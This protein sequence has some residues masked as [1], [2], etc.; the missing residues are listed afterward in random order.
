MV[1]ETFSTKRDVSRLFSKLPEVISKQ[2]FLGMRIN[3]FFALTADCVW[4]MLTSSQILNVDPRKIWSSLALT[5]LP[6]IS[7]TSWQAKVQVR[8]PV[9]TR[10]KVLGSPF[11]GFL[12]PYHKEKH[13][14]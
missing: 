12:T 13:V 8:G 9:R 10:H 2:A 11:E 5:K 3:D 7:R 14:M 1:I 6:S 4:K